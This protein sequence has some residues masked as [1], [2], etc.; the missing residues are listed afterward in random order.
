MIKLDTNNKIIINGITYYFYVIEDISGD[1]LYKTIF[2]IEKEK[3]NY[4]TFDFKRFKFVKKHYYSPID[5][6]HLNFDI[7][8][9]TYSKEYVKKCL[10]AKLKIE[11]RKEEIKN[12]QYI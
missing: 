11:L 9:F 3:V 10:D 4:W 2:Y 5:I 6:F 8:D 12:K 7:N 1:Y